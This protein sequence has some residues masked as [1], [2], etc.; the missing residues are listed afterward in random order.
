VVTCIK[1]F[2][3]I[4]FVFTVEINGVFIDVLR[5]AFTCVVFLVIV[6]LVSVIN[7]IVLLNC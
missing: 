5:I 2:S 1:G 7:I 4:E 3:M 6:K